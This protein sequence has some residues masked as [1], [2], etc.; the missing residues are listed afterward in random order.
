MEAQ[1]K[2]NK[3]VATLWLVLA[4]AVAVAGVYAC[5]TPGRYVAPGFVGL[6][7]L[8]GCL[9]RQCLSKYWLEDAV[10][11]K[12]IRGLALFVVSAMVIGALVS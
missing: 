12:T 11:Q 3:V 5:F 7:L 4:V 10:Y 2:D 1:S 8:L 6:S 9:G